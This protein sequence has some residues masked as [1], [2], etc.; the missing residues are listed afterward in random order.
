MTSV[1]TEPDCIDN[2][3]NEISSIFKVCNLKENKNVK[4]TDEHIQIHFLEE[5]KNITILERDL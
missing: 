4:P 5:S 3:K 2:M 1:G